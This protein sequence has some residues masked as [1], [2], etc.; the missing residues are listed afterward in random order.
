MIAVKPSVVRFST[1]NPRMSAGGHRY[2]DIVVDGQRI[3]EAACSY[4]DMVA[5]DEML[6]LVAFDTSKV[7]VAF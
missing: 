3:S 4:I 7:A 5:G 1:Q 6:E 2:F